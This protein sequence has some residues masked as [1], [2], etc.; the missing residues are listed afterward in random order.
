M[1]PPPTLYKICSKKKYP[2]F[3]LFIGDSQMYLP[4][5][6]CHI[7]SVLM[8]FFGVQECIKTWACIHKDTHTRK[9]LSI[10]YLQCDCGFLHLEL[11]E[12]ACSSLGLHINTLQASKT[13]K[14][15]AQAVCCKPH[16]TSEALIIKK[17]FSVLCPLFVQCLHEMVV[18]SFYIGHAKKNKKKKH[19]STKITHNADQALTI[20][21]KWLG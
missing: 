9:S 1:L 3:F 17:K 21:E 20:P 14:N 12:C 10:F 16:S 11:Q 2:F 4:D 13:E 15:V 7:I 18:S 8:L 5:Q 6:S 19:H